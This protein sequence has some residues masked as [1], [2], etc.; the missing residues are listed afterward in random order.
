MLITNKVMADDIRVSVGDWTY[1]IP[2]IHGNGLLTIGRFTSI[3][4]NVT[5]W[6]DNGG[7]H[8]DWLT[9]YPFEELWGCPAP[10]APAQTKGDVSIGHD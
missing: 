2:I 4:S 7:H 6:L 3:G 8:T 9:T 5:V 1:G 10:K